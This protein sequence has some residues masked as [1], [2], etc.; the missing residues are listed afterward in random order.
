MFLRLWSREPPGGSFAFAQDKISGHSSRNLQWVVARHFRGDGPVNGMGPPRISRSCRVRGEEASHE[1]LCAG[2]G[3]SVT[4]S[5]RRVRTRTHGGVA[6]VSGQPLPLCR[7]N[8]VLETSQWLAKRLRFLCGE[9]GGGRYRD[10]GPERFE[11][12]SC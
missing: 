9:D 4:I 3:A 12:A 8:V 7:S 5:N 11:G 6:G 1:N 10:V 2:D